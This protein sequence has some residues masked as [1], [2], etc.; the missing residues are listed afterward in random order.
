MSVDADVPSR[1]FPA[2]SPGLYLGDSSPA[3]ATPCERLARFLLSLGNEEPTWREN[4]LGR[5]GRTGRPIARLLRLHRLAMDAEI[6]AIWKRADYYWRELRAE[7]RR[8]WK[9]SLVWEQALAELQQPGGTACDARASVLRDRLLHEVFIDTH[10]A[11]FGGLSEAVAQPSPGDRAFVHVAAIEDLLDYSPWPAARQQAVFGPLLEA[12]VQ[13][14]VTA[15][16]RDQ[17]AELATRLLARFPDVLE[18]EDLLVRAETTRTLAALGTGASESAS[19]ADAATL[20]RGIARLERIR[21]DHPYYVGLYDSIGILQHIHAVKLANGGRLSAALLAVERS[22][23]YHPGVQEVIEARAK[24]QGMMQGLQERMRAVE[25][26]IAR[27]Y[28]THLNAEG[29]RL[30]NEARTGNR[31]AEDF[32]KSAAA[33]AVASARPVAAARTLWRQIGLPVPSE[34]WD[35]RARLLLQALSTLQVSSSQ[36]PEAVAAA[37]SSVAARHQDLDGLDAELICNFVRSRLQGD[38]GPPQARS[39]ATP[40]PLTVRARQRL[41]GSES[42]L[43]WLT[44]RQGLALRAMTAL[45]ALLLAIAGLITT[46]DA[47]HRRAQDS[48]WSNLQQAIERHDALGAV[49]AAESFLETPPP[50]AADA[51][52]QAAV[53]DIYSRSLVQWIARM[54]GAPDAVALRHL[55]RYRALVLRG[56]AK[57]DR[58]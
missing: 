32:R 1:W 6:G 18:Y 49:V 9:K 40:P 17:A 35:E 36:S 39:L 5:G 42:F 20:E 19:L 21:S 31:L 13:A 7:L 29:L 51:T 2:V 47:R 22:L 4:L 24:L 38:D 52:R 54:Q 28:N 33:S 16:A 46:L 55:D 44:S 8:L 23:T 43:D 53:L 57:G 48:A 34:R 50:A 26:A 27:K 11:F 30:S 56:G 25:A 14:A 15:G 58:S 37:W 12:R 45:A 10:R 3:E 41:P